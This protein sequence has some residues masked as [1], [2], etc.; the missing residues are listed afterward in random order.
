MW[1]PAGAVK[2][3]PYKEIVET[4]ELDGDVAIVALDGE[5]DRDESAGHE[6]R[7][8]ATLVEFYDAEG[9]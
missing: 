3:R 5:G 1:T 9:N 7:G 8:P 4:L 2:R 6:E